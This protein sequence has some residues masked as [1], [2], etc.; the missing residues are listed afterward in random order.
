MKTSKISSTLFSFILVFFMSVTSIAESYTR[1]T[2]DIVKSDLKKKIEV[3]KN[4]AV[5]ITTASENEFSH[6]QFDVS[7][8][9]TE[10]EIN[11]LPLNS[12]DYLRFDV[13]NF[14]NGSSSEITELPLMNELDYLRFDVNNFSNNNDISEMPVN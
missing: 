4:K 2:G 14:A 9:D 11:E 3:V 10:S 12:T 13:N 8:F 6:L 1:T 7:K 5:E